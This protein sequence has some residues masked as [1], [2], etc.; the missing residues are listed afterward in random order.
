MNWR[1]A[2]LRVKIDR[3]SY[4]ATYGKLIPDTSQTGNV[5][6]YQATEFCPAASAAF[7]N[8]S[9]TQNTFNSQCPVEISALSLTA[10]LS[11]GMRSSI[12]MWNLIPY[13]ACG[14]A[15][16][17]TRTN[18]QDGMNL[19][20]LPQ[21]NMS[22]LCDQTKCVSRLRCDGTDKGKC[23]ANGEFMGR[24]GGR[25]AVMD[26]KE[27]VNK[28]FEASSNVVDQF[29]YWNPKG[30]PKDATEAQKGNGAL[31]LCTMVNSTNLSGRADG[32][33]LDGFFKNRVKRKCDAMPADFVMGSMTGTA[34]TGGVGGANQQL[35]LPEIDV[36]MKVKFV[37]P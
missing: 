29:P 20:C 34:A 4:S 26:L 16:G 12:G 23:F 35:T 6:Q 25:L 13:V 18:M 27:S 7:A 37:K 11:A 30:T 1:Y 5:D 8:N 22:M 21:A 17:A 10:Q 9:M 14:D 3:N 36:M 19:A 28:A 2:N 24:I 32:N 15:S 33:T 31:E